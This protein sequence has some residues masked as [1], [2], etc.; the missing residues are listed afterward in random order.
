MGVMQ[1]LS[2][3]SVCKCVSHALMPVHIRY[4]IGAS[5]PVCLHSYRS[6]T[7][8]HV[9]EAV[10]NHRSAVCLTCTCFQDPVLQPHLD[11]SKGGCSW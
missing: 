1:K 7:L 11:T 5:T 2:C 4:W 3:S 6:M 9:S 8:L 10:R